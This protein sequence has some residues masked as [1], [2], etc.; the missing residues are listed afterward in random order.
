MNLPLP[1]RVE[2]DATSDPLARVPIALQR[3]FDHLGTPL[4]EVTFVVI[5]L[6]TTGI[7]PDT[8]AITEIGAVC[9]RGG[10][11]LATFQ[12]LINPGSPIPPFITVLTGIT[13]AMLYSAPAIGEVIPALLEFIGGAV[14]VGHNLRFDTAFIDAALLADGRDRLP[15]RRVDTLG[16]A[17]RLLRDEV[18][19]M[20]LGT[21]AHY[22]RVLET[23]NH[24]ALADAQAT[25]E[26][27][28]ALLER[29]ATLGVLGLDDLIEL[30][31]I[32]VHPTA[33]KLKLTA[34][35]PRLPGVY[36]F[37]N[38]NNEVFYVG[39][40]TNLRSQVRSYFGGETRAKAPPLLKE[41]VHIDH[42][43]CSDHLEAE[44]HELRLIRSH[45]PQ[46]NRAKN[47]RAG[48]RSKR[49]APVHSPTTNL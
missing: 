13:E 19:D 38:R 33:S 17:R 18:T 28:H 30:P 23:P 49:S 7:S 2:N 42:I 26:V 11:R 47:N 1:L 35:L 48:N 45:D 32:R 40:A 21:L 3:S 36:I 6:E 22:L 9:Y 41:L 5:D 43:V 4:S 31:K 20:K 37:R 44:I 46:Y 8:S 25:A 15:N 27:L 10:E 24:H 12:T 29:A 34:Q 14:L 16:L 39:K